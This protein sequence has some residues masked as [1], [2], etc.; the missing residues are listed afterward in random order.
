MR[1]CHNSGGCL[2]TS[3]SNFS[4]RMRSFGGVGHGIFSEN[5]RF[6]L[7]SSSPQCSILIFIRL[8]S[9]LY[10]LNQSSQT[11]LPR[12]T[13]RAQ[14]FLM[15]RVYSSNI[16]LYSHYFYFTIHQNMLKIKRNGNC[17]ALYFSALKSYKLKTTREGDSVCCGPSCR[18]EFRT[19]LATCLDFDTSD[20]GSGSFAKIKHAYLLQC[21]YGNSFLQ[22]K[23][24]WH[25][26]GTGKKLR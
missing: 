4:H 15:W 5:L 9:T 20:L 22:A 25:L 23:T 6:S 24:L 11:R 8:T 17:I 14:T 13:C 26:K 7:L 3:G 12:A 21:W 2:S 18:V 1:E 19:W 16:Q 10:K